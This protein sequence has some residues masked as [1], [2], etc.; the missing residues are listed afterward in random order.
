LL[1]IRR[2]QKGRRRLQAHLRLIFV[3]RYAFR[4][5]GIHGPAQKVRK[6]VRQLNADVSNRTSHIYGT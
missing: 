4:H 3:L 2:N 5:L 1:A 6:S